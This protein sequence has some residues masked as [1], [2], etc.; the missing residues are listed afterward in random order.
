MAGNTHFLNGK[1]VSEDKLVV[2]ARDV[3]FSRGY[4]VFDF[5]I[6]YPYHRPFK[7]SR[8]INRLFNSANEI[9]LKIPWS[10]EQVSQWVN[11]TLVQN[12]SGEEK[13]IKI[14]I[15][16]GISNTMVPSGTPTI[17]IIV[18]PKHEYPKENYET[19]IG[20]ITVKHKRYTPGAKTNNYIEGIKQAQL[21]QKIGAVEPI[22]FDDHQVF[23]GS[24]SNIFAVLN[25]T[26]VTPKSNILP[27][28]T[29]E[30]L[31]EILK[32]DIPIKEMD[33]TLAE[34]LGAREVFLTG[35]GKEVYPV[36]R[37]DGKKV[38][39]GRVGSITKKVMVQFKK[40]TL[41]KE[42]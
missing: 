6:T 30:T 11:D 10:K 32:L 14:I 31:L 22:Y 34:L 12:V 42:W 28:I 7:L 1:F 16:G 41:S 27:G 23:E 8:H 15:S 24:N 35:S 19:G 36:T 17:I 37:I 9:N 4:A 18:D 38:G 20:A 2:S 3:G 5:L 33:F 39:N 29:R 21:A 13:T 25:N 40:Y 26:L